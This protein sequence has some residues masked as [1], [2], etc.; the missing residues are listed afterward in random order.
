MLDSESSYS[1]QIQDRAA[2]NESDGMDAL[3]I[4]D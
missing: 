1:I 3:H 2:K 4:V